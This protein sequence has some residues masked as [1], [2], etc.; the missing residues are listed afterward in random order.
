M[1]DGETVEVPERVIVSPSSGVFVPAESG[2]HVDEGAVI[3]HVHRTGS[4]RVPVRSPFRGQ[5]VQVVAREGERV[6]VHDRIA[7]MRA[8]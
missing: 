4:D 7:W 5:L 3:G 1:Y 6:F 2:G 8:A